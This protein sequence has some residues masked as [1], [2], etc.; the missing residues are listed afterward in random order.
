[1][2]INLVLIYLLNSIMLNRYV[3]SSAFSYITQD[4]LLLPWLWEKVKLSAPERVGG[5]F[6]EKTS[7]TPLTCLFH[8]R[9]YFHMLISKI[10]CDL[11]PL[12]SPTLPM[13]P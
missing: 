3:S 12:I 6:R 1:M 7:P 11:F 10:L 5:E 4:Y 13:A 9:E 8:L 2:E